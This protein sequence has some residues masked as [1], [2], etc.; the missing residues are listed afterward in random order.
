MQRKVEYI[1]VYELLECNVC[2]CEHTSGTMTKT[3]YIFPNVRCI[4]P[5][6]LKS[7]KGIHKV[8]YI[9]CNDCIPGKPMLIQPIMLSGAISI[10]VSD[11]EVFDLP[12]E[13]VRI[14]Q[15]Q[16]TT[17][18]RPKTCRRRRQPPEQL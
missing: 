17:K 15:P 16:N 10:D 6:C 12:D 7:P 11:D 4:C 9:H 3:T 1:P 18:R 8:T 13:F 2:G 14:S 5:K